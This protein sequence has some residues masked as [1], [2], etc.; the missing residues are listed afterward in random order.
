MLCLR[1]DRVIAVD[2]AARRTLARTVLKAGR[3]R[4]LLAFRAADT[5]LHLQVACG[6]PEAGELARRLEIALVRALRLAVGFAPDPKTTEGPAMLGLSRVP[7]GRVELPT[8]GF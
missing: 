4:G 5:H 7:R 3:S 6:R 1:E 8:P 2:L